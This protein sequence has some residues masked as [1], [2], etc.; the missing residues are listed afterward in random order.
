MKYRPPTRPT[1]RDDLPGQ[2][3]LPGIAERTMRNP[4]ERPPPVK[5]M[6]PR[7]QRRRRQLDELMKRAAVAAV[8]D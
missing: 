8:T 6:T 3:A 4:G 1:G 7:Q 5:R 2:L